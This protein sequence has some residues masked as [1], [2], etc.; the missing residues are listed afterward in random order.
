[1]QLSH[2]GDD[3]L[4][5][6]LAEGSPD[7][8]QSK[9]MLRSIKNNPCVRVQLLPGC[10]REKAPFGNSKEVGAVPLPEGTG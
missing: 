3:E 9:R 1:M 10:W 6:F 2:S 5:D 4:V 7:E 8:D